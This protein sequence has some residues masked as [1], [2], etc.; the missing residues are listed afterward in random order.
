M[1][2]APGGRTER[3]SAQ[4]VHPQDQPRDEV[5]FGATVTVRGATGEERRLSIVG[6]DEASIPVTA[7][8]ARALMG[9][10][11]GDKVRL[12]TARVKQVLKIVGIGYE[13]T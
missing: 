10:R 2:I 3:S 9:H 7:P 4:L 8:I 6:V 13:T 11:V 5:A 12:E 1:R